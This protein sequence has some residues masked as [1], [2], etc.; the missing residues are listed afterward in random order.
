MSEVCTNC[1]KEFN[2]GPGLE[3]NEPLC[4]SCHASLLQ[5]AYDAYGITPEYL[6]EQQDRLNEMSECDECGENLLNRRRSPDSDSTC[7][8]CY[9]RENQEYWDSNKGDG[10]CVPDDY[11]TWY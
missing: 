5:E 8:E 1:S 4:P 3:I 10:G 7:Y 11:E 9:R 6:E 2:D